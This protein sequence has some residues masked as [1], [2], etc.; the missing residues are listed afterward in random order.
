MLND[1]TT[2]QKK[3]IRQMAVGGLLALIGFGGGIAT[4]EA[5]KYDAHQNQYKYQMIEGLHIILLAGGLLIAGN[6]SRRY[7]ERQ[8]ATPA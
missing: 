3:D 6:A 5:S 1:Y 7:R 8:E 4:N 2:L